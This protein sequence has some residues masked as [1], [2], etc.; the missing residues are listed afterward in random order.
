[1]QITEPAALP[2]LLGAVPI[3][4]AWI[5]SSTGSANLRTLLPQKPYL[6]PS[7]GRHSSQTTR[8]QSTLHLSSFMSAP[9]ALNSIPDLNPA[10]FGP[11]YRRSN[12]YADALQRSSRLPRLRINGSAQVYRRTCCHH[13]GTLW[14]RPV[15]SLS[16]CVLQSRTQQAQDSVL[17]A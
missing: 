5:N 10:C 12:R 8:R 6:S 15:L 9:Q 7:V 3:S 14:P 2:C 4:E 11:S 16:V 1:M 13:P 17:G